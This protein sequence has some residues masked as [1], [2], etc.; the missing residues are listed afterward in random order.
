MLTHTHICPKLQSSL[1][2]KLSAVESVPIHFWGVHF[3]LYIDNFPNLPPSFALL[4]PISMRHF[5]F[6]V[7]LSAPAHHHHQSWTPQDSGL[8]LQPALR[9]LTAQHLI[10]MPPVC[11]QGHGGRLQNHAALCLQPSPG[12][13]QKLFPKRK[14]IQGGSVELWKSLDFRA[15]Q[16]VTLT[17][18]PQ[19]SK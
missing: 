17:R 5:L 4:T 11:P 10:L 6:S 9:H 12:S 14:W 15:R 2:P 16:M 7:H 19:G 1:L 3:S 18:V 13:C 8:I